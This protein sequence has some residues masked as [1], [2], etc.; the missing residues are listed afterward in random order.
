[1]YCIT[2]CNCVTIF[3]LTQTKIHLKITGYFQTL[4]EEQRKNIIEKDACILGKMTK[5]DEQQRE[6]EKQSEKN[7]TEKLKL[8]SDFDDERSRHSKETKVLTDRLDYATNLVSL[9]SL[10]L[11]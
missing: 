3:L 7:I 10:I 11:A 1:M 6:L 8:E 5:I 2:E 9:I 4:A